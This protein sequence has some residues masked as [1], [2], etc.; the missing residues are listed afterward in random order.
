MHL[1]GLSGMQQSLLFADSYVSQ[2]QNYRQLR[3]GTLLTRHDALDPA[4]Q[5]ALILPS[6]IWSKAQFVFSE[7]I[8][9]VC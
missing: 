4:L 1:A 6:F 8:V 9:K 2:G 3:L 7:A 5:T